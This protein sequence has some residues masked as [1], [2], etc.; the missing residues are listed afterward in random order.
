MPLEG[1]LICLQQLGVEER[2]PLGFVDGKGSR[3]SW[4]TWDKTA[5]QPSG[6]HEGLYRGW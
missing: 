4:E 2:P 3:P 1:S 6:N 5:E